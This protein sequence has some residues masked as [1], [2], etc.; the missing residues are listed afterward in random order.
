MPVV[1]GAAEPERRCTPSL[2]IVLLY[3]MSSVP[4]SLLRG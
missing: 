1:N 4:T 2:Q 3:A